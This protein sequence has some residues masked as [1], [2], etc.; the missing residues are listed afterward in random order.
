MDMG[1]LNKKVLITGSTS[2]VGKGIAEAFIKEGARVVVTSYLEKEVIDTVKEFKDKYTEALVEGVVGDL[3]KLEDA[4]KLYDEVTKD[5]P[6]DILVNNLGIYPV[7]PFEQITDEEWYH[8]FN[9]NVMS[10][11]RLCRRALPDMLKINSGKIINISSE[12]GLRPNGDLIHYSTTKSAILGLSRGLAETTKGS[13]VT[14]NSV[15]PVTTWTEG[16]AKY[17]EELAKKNGNSVEQEK[18]NYFQNGNDRDS[19]LQRFLTTEEVA[20][21]VLF[22]ATNDGINGNSIL[23]D[24]GV[25]KHI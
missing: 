7:K 16:I 24:A 2:G 18:I 6:I 17:F 11:V 4:N 19:L 8:I 23:I 1:L 25:I 10:I 21:T 14:V 15:L 22:A 9:I 12:A 3:S 20:K 5:G 13:K